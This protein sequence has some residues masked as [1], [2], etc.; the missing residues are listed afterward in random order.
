MRRAVVVDTARIGM[1]KAFR[2]SLNN[3][4]P[5]DQLAFVMAALVDRAGVERDRIEDVVVGCAFPEGPQGNNVARVSALLAGFPET[6]P[7]VTINRFCSSGSQSI[8]LAAS[9]IVTG[10]ADVAIG[11]GVETITMIRDGSYNKKR[12]KNPVAAERF[13][14]LYMAMGDTAEIVAERYGVSRED[15]DRYG[16]LSQQRTAEAQQRGLFDGEIIP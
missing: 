12:V 1:T 16:L 5:D 13:P 10:S 4:R 7:G 6:T 2:G 9:E 3:T 11:A 14:G 8:A 15:Q